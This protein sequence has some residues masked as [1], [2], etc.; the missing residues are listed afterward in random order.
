MPELHLFARVSSTNDVV[1]RRAAAGAPARTTAIAE[2]Q[3]DGRGQ[4]GRRWDS[5]PA[6]SLLMSVL[7]RPPAIEALGTTPIRVGSAVARAIEECTGIDVRIKWPN[8]LIVDGRKIG[9]ILCEAST[10]AA[11]AAIVAGIGINVTQQA[12]DFPQAIT[13]TAISLRQAG[14]ASVDRGA[15]AGAVLHAL[16]GHEDRIAA[17]LEEAELQAF[18]ARD[19]LHGAAVV[20]DDGRTGI[21]AGITADGELRVRTDAGTISVHTKTVRTTGVRDVAHE[22]AP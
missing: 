3:T 7:L 1:R 5:P 2:T 11:G 16:A 21:A 8:D 13:A 9:G 12:H 19:A 14:A 4:H 18:A 6:A 10:S 22:R 17:P 20:L 15:L